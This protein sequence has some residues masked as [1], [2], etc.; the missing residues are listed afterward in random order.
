MQGQSIN[1]APYQRRSYSDMLAEQKALI[2]KQQQ[3]NLASRV[4]AQRERAEFQYKQLEKIYGFDVNGWSQDT[5]DGFKARQDYISNNLKTGGYDSVVDLIKDVGELSSLHGM[6]ASDAKLNADGESAYVGWES[7]TEQWTDPNSEFTGN[8]QDRMRR[9]GYTR[10]GARSANSRNVNGRIVVDY[11]VMTPDG[12]VSM[13]DQMLQSNP[14]ARV[15]ESENGDVFVVTE[16]G[17]R[18]QVSGDVFS[19]P[20]VNNSD[21]WAPPSRP[22]GD[23]PPAAFAV[24]LHRDYI[25]AIR[26]NDQLTLSQKRQAVEVAFRSTLN[27]GQKDST[28]ERLERSA[29]AFWEQQTGLQWNGDNAAS[30]PQGLEPIDFYIQTALNFADLDPTRQ[31][32]GPTGPTDMTPQEIVRQNM[33]STPGVTADSEGY[34]TESNNPLVFEKYVENEEGERVLNPDYLGDENITFRTIPLQGIGVKWSPEGSGASRKLEVSTVQIARNGDALVTFLAPNMST[35]EVNMLFGD[36][37][38]G[39]EDGPTAV[40]QLPNGSYVYRIR[41]NDQVQRS[42]MQTAIEL[43]LPP[44]TVNGQTIPSVWRQAY[45]DLLEQQNQ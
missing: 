35:E 5:I 2:Q 41:E 30:H 10:G 7:G 44:Q 8:E 36:T 17:S 21:N 26:G 32:T 34:Q 19:N 25:D 4:E 38:G 23:I 3:A 12:P 18:T 43:V 22:L 27:H 16:D 29:I 42:L 28:R 14:S 1:V 40:T 6:G 24:D 11:M 20:M 45:L 9:N 15:E 39:G 37:S 13:R 31:Q 33:N